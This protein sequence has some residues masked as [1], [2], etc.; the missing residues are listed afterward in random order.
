MDWDKLRIFHAVAEA[1]SLTHA[2]DRLNLSQSAVSRQI[3][4]LEENLGATLFHRHTRGLILTEQGEVLLEACSRMD[5]EL[6]AAQARLRDASDVAGGELRVTVPVGFGTI[7]LAP[8]L[9]RLFTANPGLTMDLILT[10]VILDLAMREADVAIRMTPP[11]QADLVRRP[12]MEVSLRLYASQA[13]VEK[14]GEPETIDDLKRHNILGYSPGAQQSTTARDW[15]RDTLLIEQFHALTVNNYFGLL[16]AAEHDLGIAALPDYAVIGRPKIRQ[17]A[18]ELSS[19][20]FT[21][22]LAYPE[23]LRHSKRVQ[24]FRDFLIE[25]VATFQRLSTELSEE[26]GADPEPTAPLEPPLA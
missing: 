15:M 13:Y 19:P 16:Q 9:E 17:V 10:E 5:S 26:S 4:A 11:Q 24:A 21:V 2:G 14:Y 23:V 12:L 20:P 6:T 25:E 18:K 7:W 22:Y 8:R 1:G 3:R